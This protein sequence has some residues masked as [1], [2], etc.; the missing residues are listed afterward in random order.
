MGKLQYLQGK[1]Q[2]PLEMRVTVALIPFQIQDP[3]VRGKYKK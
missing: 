1:K 3:E 2:A